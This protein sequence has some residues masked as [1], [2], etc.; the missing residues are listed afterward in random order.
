ML[1]IIIE[2]NCPF[3]IIIN[4]FSFLVPSSISFTYNVYPASLFVQEIIVYR[5]T[6]KNDVVLNIICSIII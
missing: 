4:N 2:N 6:M 3:E 5:Y 1:K